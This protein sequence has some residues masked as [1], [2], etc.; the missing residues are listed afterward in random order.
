MGMALGGRVMKYPKISLWRCLH[1]FV[2]VKQHE[3][4]CF[5]SENCTVCEWR[6]DLAAEK[7]G[8]KIPRNSAVLCLVTHRAACGFRWCNW[9]ME[10]HLASW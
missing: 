9:C 3:I 4:A 8:R 10:F 7:N 2:A 1:S 5:K 6:R